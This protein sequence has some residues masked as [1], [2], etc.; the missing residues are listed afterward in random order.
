ME[1][2]WFSDRDEGLMTSPGRS[3][4]GDAMAES[5]WDVRVTVLADVTV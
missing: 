2:F 5:C 4:V 1:V 3:T